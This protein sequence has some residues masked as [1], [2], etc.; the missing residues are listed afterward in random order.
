MKIGAVVRLAQDRAGD[1]WAGRCPSFAEIR[2]VAE[3]L[4]EAGAD[5][6]WLADHLLYRY[7]SEPTVGIWECW[8]MLTALAMATRR[9]QVGTLVMCT[10][11]RNPA[12]LAK[13][14]ATLDE[15]SGG[16]LILGLGAGWNR[17]EFD[18][19]DLPF[20]HRVDRFEEAL[21]IIVPL[22]REGRVDFEGRY[23]VARDCELAPRDPVSGG[24]PILIGGEGPRML[25]LA[26]RYGTMWNIGYYG[27]VASFAPART[28]FEAARTEIGG[29]AAG[30]EPTVLL[31]V[32]WA[33]LG[34]LPSWFEDDY[35]TGTA[36]EIAAVWRQFEEAGV[37]HVMC[38]YHPNTRESLQR[39]VAAIQVYKQTAQGT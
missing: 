5:S 6:V 37:T 14:A 30:V 27:D 10:Q 13:M 24:P 33:D 3:A 11:F 21:Q 39:L 7:P 28:A 4:E 20:D 23:Y 16:R 38:Q 8:T 25:R 12:I 31:K 29:D 35:L 36:E 22:L 26:A 9:V 17:P 19:F 2:E 18:A 15:V 32:G 1:W 34:Q